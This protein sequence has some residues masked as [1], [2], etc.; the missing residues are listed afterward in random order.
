[1]ENKDRTGRVCLVGAG[2]STELMTLEG[3]RQLREAQ[4]VLYD[5]LLDPQVLAMVPQEAELI[6]VGK[7]CGHHSLKQAEINSLLVEKTREGKR[8]VRLKGGDSFV[9]GRGGEE[10]QALQAAGIPYDIVPGVT[11]AVAVPEHLGIPVTHRGLARS[12]TVVTGHTQN[13][14]LEDWQALAELQGTLVFLMGLSQ[15]ESICGQLVAHGKQ[16]D[17]P[18]SVLCGGYSERQLRLDGTLASIAEKAQGKAFAPAIIVVGP[19]AAL[20]LESAERSSV[21]VTGTRGFCRKVAE[22]LQ[23]A[24]LE[25]EELPMLEVEPLL[26]QIPRDILDAS[27]LAF[28]SRNGVRM[29]GQWLQQHHI[30]H[31]KLAGQWFACIGEGTAEELAALGFTADLVPDIFTAGA[32]G[33]ALA[34]AMTSKESCVLL[35]AEKASPDLSQALESAGRAYRDV[36]VYRVRPVQGRTAEKKDLSP[37]LM[38]FGS[39]GGVHAFCQQYTLA[40]ET[41]ILCIGPITAQAA[42]EEGYPATIIATVHSVD[43]LVQAVPF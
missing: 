25:V 8:V 41:Q 26:E 11:S 43:G 18:V 42:K 31:R 19:V 39:A 32:L 2:C 33:K 13:G 21:T 37:R 12:F 22:K 10:L 4:V 20:H 9:L 16:A 17:T 6:P 27:W 28:T 23:A 1:M 15:L 5:A 35:R 14:D 24:D 34:D 36:P 7:R 30:D 3:L 29:F 40:P 38:I